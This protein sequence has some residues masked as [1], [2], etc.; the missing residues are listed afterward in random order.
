V[1]AY[2]LY[3]SPPAVELF[4]LNIFNAIVLSTME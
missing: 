4:D 1:P 3:T 2:T